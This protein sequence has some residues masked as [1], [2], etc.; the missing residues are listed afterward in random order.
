MKKLVLMLAIIGLT[1]ISYAQQKSTEKKPETMKKTVIARLTIKKESADPF[2]KLAQKMVEQTHKE[3]GCLTY[4]LYKSCFG[5]DQEFIFF[6]EYKD[7]AALDIHNN[8]EY[9]KQFLASIT[10]LL[11]GKPIVEVF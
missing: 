10:T 3:A 4:T 6:E 2:M 7:Q 9:L 1:G 5:P 8:S 11:D